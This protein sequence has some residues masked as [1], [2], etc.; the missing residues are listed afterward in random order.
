M[1][2]DKKPTPPQKRI[3]E[4]LPTSKSPDAKE[5]TDVGEDIDTRSNAEPDTPQEMETEPNG[6][7]TGK[8]KTKDGTN[9]NK[10][11][12]QQIFSCCDP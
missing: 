11:N 2:L 6:E 5:A 12:Q 3:K 4:E 7:T 9:S 1:G 8:K 10:H